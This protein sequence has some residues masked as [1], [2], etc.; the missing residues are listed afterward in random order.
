MDVNFFQQFVIAQGESD[1]YSLVI[2]IAIWGGGFKL[3]MLS[4][5]CRKSRESG[6]SYQGGK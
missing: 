5:D 2:E 4:S 1:L 3:N 6:V